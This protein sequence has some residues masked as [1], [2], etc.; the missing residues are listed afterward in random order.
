MCPVSHSNSSGTL[1][2]C[3]FGSSPLLRV[4]WSTLTMVL[5]KVRFPTHDVVLGGIHRRIRVLPPFAPASAL[6]ITILKHWGTRCYL[7]I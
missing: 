4:G 5:P 2:R 3:R 7:H 6:L 1:A